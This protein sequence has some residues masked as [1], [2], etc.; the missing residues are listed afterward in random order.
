LI[1]I[2]AAQFIGID[3]VDVPIYRIFRLDRLLEFLA[4]GKL[5][6]VHPEL[7]DDP[8]E[9]VLEGVFVRYTEDPTHTQVPLM[10]ARRAIYGQCW[11]LAGLSDTLWRA[12]SSVRLAEKDPQRNETPQWE[13]VQVKSTPRKLMSSLWDSTPGDRANTCFIGRVSYHPV[14][15]ALQQVADAVGHRGAGAFDEARHMAESMLL[16]RDSFGDEREVRLIH[17]PSDPG[18]PP[19]KVHL[20]D[21]AIHDLIDEIVIDPRLIEFERKERETEIQKAGYVGPVPRSPLYMR[22]LVELPIKGPR[23]P[24]V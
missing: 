8:F 16:K 2:P 20:F 11:S 18:D 12:Y 17:V 24:G 23:P 4:S 5:A 7:W 1:K 6:L 15:N 10:R 9:R 21:I 3:D 14:A 22:P 19:P 13:G